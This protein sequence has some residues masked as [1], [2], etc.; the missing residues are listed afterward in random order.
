MKRQSSSSPSD[1]ELSCKVS[2]AEQRA[3]F[4][5]LRHYSPRLVEIGILLMVIRRH[6]FD[7]VFGNHDSSDSRLAALID[8]AIALSREEVVPVEKAY[9]HFGALA[10][11][12]S[13]EE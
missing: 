1:F 5:M 10:D 12:F 9:E 6:I 11:A 13:G 3:R 4:E 2:A 7:P 8:C